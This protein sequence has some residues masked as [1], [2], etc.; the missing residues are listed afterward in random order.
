MAR[1]KVSAI[2]GVNAGRIRLLLDD[3][4]LS[5][6]DLLVQVGVTNDCNLTIVILPPIYGRINNASMEIPDNVI[7]A[8]LDMHD[9]LRLHS[10]WR[11]AQTARREQ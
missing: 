5:P 3:Q 1:Q 2:L 9:D 8:K 4:M 11:A 7:T 6:K 10:S